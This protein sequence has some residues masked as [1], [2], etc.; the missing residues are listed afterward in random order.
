MWLSLPC[1]DHTP[2][3]SIDKMEALSD[4]EREVFGAVPETVML[5][6]F[7][8]FEGWYVEHVCERA[9]A[10]EL[11]ALVVDTWI[12]LNIGRRTSGANRHETQIG[13]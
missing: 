4:F 13:A 10:K 8:S 6:S 11:L 7:R 5:R 1:S 9:D 2:Q 3:F 12:N